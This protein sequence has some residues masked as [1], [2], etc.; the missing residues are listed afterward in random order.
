MPAREGQLET[1]DYSPYVIEDSWS[2]AI[3]VATT[4]LDC[5]ENETVK[6]AQKMGR[7]GRTP[8]T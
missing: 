4:K 2:A 5:W 8:F 3:V 1:P 6:T 7:H